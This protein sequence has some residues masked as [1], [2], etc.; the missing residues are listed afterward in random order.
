MFVQICTVRGERSVPKLNT[1][2][3]SQYHPSPRTDYTPVRVL[4]T[5]VSP[6]AIMV[7]KL[8]AYLIEITLAEVSEW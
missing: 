2:S 5:A 8:D 6:G 4:L 7:T 3:G 1:T